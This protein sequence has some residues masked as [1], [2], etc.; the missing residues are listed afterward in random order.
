MPRKPRVDI[1]GFYHVINRGVEKRTVF[2]DEPD[3]EVFMR[4]L[5]KSALIYGFKLHAYA[6]M[7]NHY[8][9]L[10]ETFTNNLSLI[11][12]QINSKYSIYFNKKYDRVGPL[13]Q[14]RFKSFYVYDSTYLNI[15]IKYIENNPAKAGIINESE[16]Y[17]HVS[18]NISSINSTQWDESD[19]QKWAKWINSKFVVDE[20]QNAI[21]KI[22][23]SLSTYFNESTISD[24]HI[25]DAW[26]DG[27]K[28]S[29]IAQYLKLST[30]M[31]SRRVRR[32]YKKQELFSAI[33]QKGL[34]WSYD[35][36]LEYSESLDILL[37]ESVLKYGDF[38]DLKQIF[39]LYGRRVIK[40]IWEKKLIN[41][42]RFIKLNYF[43]ARIFF[44]MD[45]EAVFFKGGV[46]DREQKLRMLAS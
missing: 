38:T 26:L 34:F 10:I 33:K 41:D 35:K 12:R 23:K 18:K 44:N 15:V 9:L 6:L 37:I 16:S 1:K 45:V 4:V 3:F 14:G 32:Y 11:M 5:T 19:N 20:R 29:S 42:R 28:Q 30:A 7:P 17:L 36:K 39:A 2:I 46:S 40:N 25:V 24:F 22:S 13:W 21:G 27:Y 8:H 43:L 31:I